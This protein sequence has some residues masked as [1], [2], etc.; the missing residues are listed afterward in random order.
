VP[1]PETALPVVGIIGG[2]QLARMMAQAAISLG[3]GVRVLADSASDSA[4]LICHDVVVGDYREYADLATLA[5]GCDAVTFDHE[6]VPL[7]H[8]EKLIADGVVVWPGPQ[9]LPFVQDKIAMR[10]RLGELGLPVPEWAVVETADEIVGFAERHGWPVVAKAA[11]GG[12]DGKGVWVLRTPSDAVE[13]VGHASESGIRLYVEQHIAFARELAALAVR[14]ATGETAVWPTVQTVQTDGICTEVIAPAP[15]LDAGLDAEARAL[16]LGLVQ[17]LDIVG[18]LAVELFETADGALLVNELAMRPHNC[19]HWTIDGSTTSQFEQHLRAVV[20]W[21]LG[22]TG[23]LAPVT[24]MANL[25]GGDGPAAADIGGRTPQAL[26]ADPGVHLHL[27]GKG[28]RAGRKIGH[29]NVLGDDTGPTRDRA[30]AAVDT[31]RGDS[32]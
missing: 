23:T 21:P 30:R 22:D 7:A 10:S 31:L 8:V 5:A 24:V 28:V 29:V 27:Y 15:L 4:A 3:I 6:Q 20:G 19:G 11:S 25:L 9:S 16:A 26:R 32:T 18:L 17:E 2:G 14:S 1:H 13:L 12:Y